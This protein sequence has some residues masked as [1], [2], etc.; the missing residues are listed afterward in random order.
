MSSS[1]GRSWCFTLNNP[2]ES[3]NLRILGL[4]DE[5]LCRYIVVGREV[6]ESG[7]PHL[8]GFIV[9]VNT[10]RFN[11]VKALIGVRAHLELARGDADEN[12][13]YCSK[14][15][16][17][18]EQ[19]ERPVSNKSKGSKEKERW[20]DARR[21]AK[22]GNF[23]EIPADILM[24]CYGTIQKLFHEEN[25][26]KSLADNSA[27]DNFWIWGPTGSGKSYGVRQKWSE[28]EIYLKPLNKWF[29]G[30]AGEKVVLVED[31]DPSHEKWIGYFLKIWSDHYKFR[32][33]VKGTS[34]M[35][36]P[37]I[38]VVTSQYQISSIFSDSQTVDALERRFR[39]T[40]LS[41]AVNC[42]CPA[43]MRE[44]LQ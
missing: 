18:V 37:K 31:I 39:M 41:P 35:L 4:Y 30:Y 27:M 2:T 8:Q 32:A 23:D 29:D 43:C 20:E 16:D 13:E 19:G 44:R 1:R 17:F 6:G 5:G 24:R 42:V 40:H 34:I 11:H 12:F 15:D 28:D 3:E 25:L 36:R 10:V 14:D 7:T 9:F 33:E 21:L 26:K 22:E 38:I